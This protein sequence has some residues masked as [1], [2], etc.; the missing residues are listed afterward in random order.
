[1]PMLC[2]A[3]EKLRA[4]AGGIFRP[5]VKIG[6]DIDALPSGLDPATKDPK[7]MVRAAGQRLLYSN[8]KSMCRA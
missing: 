3:K 1:M 6:Y 2:I 7:S 8:A 5:K 4:I